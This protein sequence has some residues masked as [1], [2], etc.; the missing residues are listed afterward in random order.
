MNGERKKTIK[1]FAN[2]I[3]I[4]FGKIVYYYLLNIHEKRVLYQFK[5]F[6]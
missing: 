1:H 3:N 6:I 4:F 5:I 2:H